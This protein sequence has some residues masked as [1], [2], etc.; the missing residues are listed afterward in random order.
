MESR[1]ALCELPVLYVP[2]SLHEEREVLDAA[3][4]LAGGISVPSYRD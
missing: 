4:A 1:Q 3:P 2:G